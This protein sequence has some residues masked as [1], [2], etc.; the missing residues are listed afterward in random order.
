MHGDHTYHVTVH[1]HH[2]EIEREQQYTVQCMQYTFAGPRHR[3]IQNADPH[4]QM[5]M[6]SQVRY[7]CPRFNSPALALRLNEHA[8]L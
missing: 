8:A 4:C 1:A 7:L 3:I 2:T 6:H 5:S